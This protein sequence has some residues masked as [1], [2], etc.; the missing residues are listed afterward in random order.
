MTV[1]CGQLFQNSWSSARN[2]LGP[3][4]SSERMPGRR[5]PPLGS[6]SGPYCMPQAAQYSSNA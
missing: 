6:A 5:L 4:V 1:A 3:L 2:Q